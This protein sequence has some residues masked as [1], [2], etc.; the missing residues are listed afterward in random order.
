MNTR[1]HECFATTDDRGEWLWYNR[2]GNL[3][4]Q[5]LHKLSHKN[6]VTGLPPIEIP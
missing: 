6:L 4:F 3:N 1:K 5:H 2:F